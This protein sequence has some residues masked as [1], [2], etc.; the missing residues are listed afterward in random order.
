VHFFF[1]LTY[2]NLLAPDAVGCPDGY[3][4]GGGQCYYI[5]QLDD[6]MEKISW[7]AA[8]NVCAALEPAPGVFP[9]LANFTSIPQLVS[10]ETLEHVPN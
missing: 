2:D 1:P 8:K 5:S 9:V 10:L 6:S 4:L 3:T 7:E